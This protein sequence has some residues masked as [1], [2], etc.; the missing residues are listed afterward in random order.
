MTRRDW[1][2]TARTM[3]FGAL[4]AL[5]APAVVALAQEEAGD[6][7]AALR[8]TEMLTTKELLEGGAPGERTETFAKSDGR[9]YCV[10]RVENPSATETS[11]RVT[12]ERAEGEPEAREGGLS[13]SILATRRYRTVART[14]TAREPGRYRCVARTETGEVLQHVDFSV[15]E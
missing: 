3:A 6:E 1:H 12:F 7:G 13:L 4:L 10:I 9:I 5:A 8:V 11:I 14:S 2:P 15:T